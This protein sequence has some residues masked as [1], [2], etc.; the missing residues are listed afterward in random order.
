[1][2][3]REIDTGEK[4]WERYMVGTRVAVG[5]VPSFSREGVIPYHTM[6][7]GASLASYKS[8]TELWR[9]LQARTAECSVPVDSW[10]AF[11]ITWRWEKNLM[12]RLC[13]RQSVFELIPKAGHSRRPSLFGWDCS[14]PLVDIGL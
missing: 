9:S 10:Q 1:M 4:L 7:L 8:G 13:I 6:R 3:K 5:F 11:T 14:F 12:V 2:E